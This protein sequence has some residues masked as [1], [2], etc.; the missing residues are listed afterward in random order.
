MKN[1]TIIKQTLDTGKTYFTYIPVLNSVLLKDFPDGRIPYAV[2][3]QDGAVYHY[4][5]HGQSATK[6]TKT[7]LSWIISK[8]FQLTPKQFIESFKSN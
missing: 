5:H 4:R 1:L 7:N 6:A 8:I 3:W 2:L